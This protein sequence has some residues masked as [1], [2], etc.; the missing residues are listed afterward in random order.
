MPLRLRLLLLFVYLFTE[1]QVFRRCGLAAHLR[2][3]F[4]GGAGVVQGLA[5]ARIV[6][7]DP[8]CHPSAFFALDPFAP[9]PQ[10]STGH[11]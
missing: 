9:H 7:V 11:I 10:A 4:F 1:L 8:G 5:T 6:D 2:S 3:F